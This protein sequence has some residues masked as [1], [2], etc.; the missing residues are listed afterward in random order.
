MNRIIACALAAALVFG[1]FVTPVQAAGP[2]PTAPRITEGNRHRGNGRRPTPPPA[3][4]DSRPGPNQRPQGQNHR[5]QAP[6][7]HYRPEYRPNDHRRSGSSSANFGWG[8]VV[9]A[10]IGSVIAHTAHR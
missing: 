10:V 2:A 7:P 1:V 8:V 4:R 9:G 6:Q 3:P 5:P